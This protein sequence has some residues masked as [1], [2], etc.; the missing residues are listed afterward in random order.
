[1]KTP[2][3]GTGRSS[4]PEHEW[5]AKQQPSKGGH[6]LRQPSGFFAAAAT[7]FNYLQLIDFKVFSG[8]TYSREKIELAHTLKDA[9][10]TLE[11]FKELVKALAKKED[12]EVASLTVALLKDDV[13]FS[14]M[15]NQQSKLDF[16]NTPL[17][18]ETIKEGDLQRMGGTAELLRKRE[19]ELKKNNKV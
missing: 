9:R 3:I 8:Y 15:K 11:Q 5:L 13:R 4:Q 14:A 2:P 16:I 6:L 10:T 12:L 19:V 1:M 18:Q 17:P 7:F